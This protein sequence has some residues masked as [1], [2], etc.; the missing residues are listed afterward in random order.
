VTLLPVVA[1][2]GRATPTA[3]QNRFDFGRRLR[4]L[5]HADFERILHDGRRTTDQRLTMW[6]LPNGLP[7]PR[8]G[9]VVGRKYGGAVRRNRAKRLLREAFRLQQYELPAGF[10]LVCSPRAGVDLNLAGAMESLF[11]LSKRLARRD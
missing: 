10:D 7:H 1:P 3:S 6:V 11:R 4:V 9:L 8:L 2:R 5:K